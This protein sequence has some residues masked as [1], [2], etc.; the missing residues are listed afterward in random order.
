[1]ERAGRLEN[2]VDQLDKPVVLDGQPLFCVDVLYQVGKALVV[3][4][5]FF[6]VQVIPLFFKWQTGIQNLTFPQDAAKATPQAIEAAF[7]T[8]SQELTS[9]NMTPNFKYGFTQAIKGYYTTY[10][11]ISNVSFQAGRLAALEEVKQKGA[12]AVLAE[13]GI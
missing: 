8:A 5:V 4:I 13:A 6:L 10:W 3:I 11:L 7:V 9:A 2:R 12:T 1:M